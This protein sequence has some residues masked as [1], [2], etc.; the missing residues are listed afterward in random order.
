M[1]VYLKE[2]LLSLIISV[3]FIFILSLIISNTRINENIISPAIISISSFSIIIGA[4][5][6][7]KIKKKKGILNGAILGM[8]YMICMYLLSSIILRDFT[9]TAKMLVMILCGILG[10]A[11]GGIIGVNLKNK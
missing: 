1:R 6:V 2:M 9:I 5:R 7:S 8:S 10:G 4:A 11:I 3:I